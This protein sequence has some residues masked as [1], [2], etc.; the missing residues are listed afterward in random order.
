M[1][2]T[3]RGRLESR[4]AAT[5]LPLAVALVLAAALPAW[6]P[7]A[8]AALM[9]GV[10]VALDVLVYHRLFPYQAGWLALPLGV[11]ELGIVVGLSFALGLDA[12]LGPALGF[13][14]GA[15]AFGQVVGHA[16]LPRIRL[17][18]A[19]DGGELGRQGV[20]VAAGVALMLVATGGVAWATRPPTVTL[21]RASTRGRCSSITSSA[22]KASPAPS[23]AGESS[24]SP[25]AS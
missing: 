12:P 10:G 22:S 9:I 15:W 21:R 13:F 6:W 3:L 11:V 8:L 25:T 4:L 18:Y 16:L 24:C 5:L 14:A 20:T 2:Y 17:E 19:E 23:S 1:A 7:A